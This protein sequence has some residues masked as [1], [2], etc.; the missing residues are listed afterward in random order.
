VAGFLDSRNNI[1]IQILEKLKK[2][3]CKNPN[4]RIAF[5]TG[6]KTKKLKRMRLDQITERAKASGQIG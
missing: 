4:Y 3:E 2:L 1:E 6:K 5:P